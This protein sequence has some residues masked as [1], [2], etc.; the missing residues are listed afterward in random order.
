MSLDEYD[1]CMNDLYNLPMRGRSI[2]PEDPYAAAETIRIP[3][4]DTCHVLLY[5]AA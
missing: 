1:T 2:V 4:W 3:L 5:L